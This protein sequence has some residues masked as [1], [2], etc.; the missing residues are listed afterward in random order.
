MR[1]VG[2]CGTVIIG[3]RTADR[4]KV[5]TFNTRIW[6]ESFTVN[7]MLGGRMIRN[8]WVCAMTTQFVRI[9][10]PPAVSVFGIETRVVVCASAHFTNSV[11]H[12][13]VL[14]YV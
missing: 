8:F 12:N 13:S 10:H 14:L 6:V 3:E 1:T 7:T 4:G 5:F 2:T 9:V 11:R